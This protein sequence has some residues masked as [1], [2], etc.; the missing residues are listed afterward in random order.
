MMDLDARRVEL[1]ERLTALREERGRAILTGSQFD[2]G[3]VVAVEAEL[4]ALS[5]AEAELD[6]QRAQVAADAER[7]RQVK[8][9]RQLAETEA[10]RL[11]A[12]CQLEAA[13][14]AMADGIKAFE[15]ETTAARSLLRS[16]GEST[17]PLRDG[18]FLSQLA[19]GVLRSHGQRRWGA[20]EWG[21]GGSIAARGQQPWAA[22]CALPESIM[23]DTK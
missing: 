21:D 18:D 9:R 5:D 1:E 11:V 12:I 7:E 23:G 14:R 3:G 2:A 20:L 17:V 15:A 4:A 22:Q 6:R 8:L 13:T 16:L 10:R 19:A